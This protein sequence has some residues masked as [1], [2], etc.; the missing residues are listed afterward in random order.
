M[1]YSK[2]FQG[3]GRNPSSF[4]YNYKFYIFYLYQM[5]L[6]IKFYLNM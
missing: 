3:D 2:Y 5:N 6:S 1:F 4:R